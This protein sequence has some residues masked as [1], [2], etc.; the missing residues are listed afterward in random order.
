V[1][2]ASCATNLEPTEAPTIPWTEI[3]PKCSPREGKECHLKIT[4]QQ[5]FR[6]FSAYA[7]RV[8]PKTVAV[9]LTNGGTASITS[10]NDCLVNDQGYRES[11]CVT[12]TPVFYFQRRGFFLFELSY[13]EGSGYL[14]VSDRDGTETPLSAAPHFSPDGAAFA[15]VNGATEDQ[16][17]PNVVEVWELRNGTPARDF[18]YEPD[19]PNWGYWFEAWEAA[20]RVRLRYRSRENQRE[21]RGA[22]LIRG[23]SGWSIVAG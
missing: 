12:K 16:Y 5:F 22:H 14:L 15:V 9:R 23:T 10:R 17:D 7:R 2:A 6:N 20:D 11:K 4:E 3:A 8:D 13:Y 19:D 18:A 21:T 1:L